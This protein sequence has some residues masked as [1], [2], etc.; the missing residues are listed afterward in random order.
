MGGAHGEDESMERYVVG[1]V[2][3]GVRVGVLV[4]CGS[5]IEHGG[6]AHLSA[7]A[8][9]SGVLLREDEGIVY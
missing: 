6:W 9:G 1:V 4:G 7:A 2:V 5:E 3:T 8:L